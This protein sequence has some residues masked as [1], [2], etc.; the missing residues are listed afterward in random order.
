MEKNCWNPGD[1]RRWFCVYK[2]SV[3]RALTIVNARS[4]DNMSV[5]VF[6][7]ICLLKCL[8]A[9]AQESSAKMCS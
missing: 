2:M 4:Y 8:E 7:M 1:T 3:Q 9:V 5:K 6:M